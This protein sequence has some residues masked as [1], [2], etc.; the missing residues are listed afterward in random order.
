MACL[1]AINYDPASAA[2]KSCATRI[3]MTALDT[4]NLRITFTAP[5]N[6]CVLVR[7]R[8]L[9]TGASSLPRIMLGVLDGSTVRL[10]M[11]PTG[12]LVGTNNTTTLLQ[13][14]VV[15]VISGLTPGNS[16]TWDAAYSVDVLTASTNIRYGGP[17]DASG[18]DA[19]GGFIFEVWSA[20]NLLASKLYDPA[21][22]T[23]VATTS[24]AAMTAFDTTNL[25][26]TITVPSSGKILWRVRTLQHGVATHGEYLLGIM[27]GSSVIA[28]AAPIW[29]DPTNG[30]STSRM[31]MDAT[32]II[33][34]L[35]PGD[36]HTYD[37]A[38][39]IQTVASAGGTFAYG[40][41]DDTTSDNAV[42]AI[43]FELW[44]A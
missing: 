5:T 11:A 27:E 9:V 8:G 35:N 28:R 43:A 36:S 10:R 42:G 13:Q 6:G 44:T 22:L 20:N 16:Y 19:F 21:S 25:R 1:G 18:N 4:T 7:L 17:N 41:P 34:G 26:S 38:Y 14:E 2:S 3:A 30:T 24:L 33:T 12:S 15:G 32:G 31:V 40:G 29:A 39:A 37:A 23:T